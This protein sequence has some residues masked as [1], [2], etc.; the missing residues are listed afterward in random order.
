MTTD[1]H[2]PGFTLV[3]AM[4]ANAMMALLATLL[5]ATWAGLGRPTA[6]LIERSQVLHEA[7]M[8]VA[9]LGADL[10]GS[11][12]GPQASL[13]PREQSRF[14]GWMHPAGSQLWLCFDGGPEPS[15]VADWAPP[16]TVIV[17]QLESDQL[18]RWDRTAGASFTVARHVE[19]LQVTPR[20]ARTVEIRLTFS[21]RKVKSTYI[22]VAR[23]PCDQ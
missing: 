11:L 12:S 20:D 8:A 15:G 23:M 22:L 3:E 4:V 19:D 16:D 13:G 2:R 6:D 5:A 18:V 1:R 21:F 10:G 17:Y 9:A 14:L 7:H